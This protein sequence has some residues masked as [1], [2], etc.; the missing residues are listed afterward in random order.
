MNTT[1]A[2][3]ITAITT[4]L[5]ALMLLVI[6]V[7]VTMLRRRKKVSFLDGGDADLRVAIRVQGNFTEYVP[8][9]L[10]LMGLIE[11]M[12]FSPA[13][14]YVFGAALIVARA[15]HALGLYSGRFP[16]RALGAGGTWLL[17]LIGALLVL[18]RAS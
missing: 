1:I 2:V 3:P 18:G 16:A 17:L 9:L 4:A 13:V 7:R 15:A 11:A 8:M 5:L 6:S 12:H 10:I 14:V